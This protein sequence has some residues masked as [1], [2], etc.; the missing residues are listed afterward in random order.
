VLFFCISAPRGQLE[1]IMKPAVHPR[2]AVKFRDVKDGDVACRGE[3]MAY[4]GGG[5]NLTGEPNFRSRRLE[6]RARFAS[7]MVRRCW[8]RRKGPWKRWA[9]PKAP[10]SRSTKLVN[11]RH[12]F[13]CVSHPQP[14]QHCVDDNQRRCL[15][16]G[17]N[18]RKDLEAA[19]DDCASTTTNHPAARAA[20]GGTRHGPRVEVAATAR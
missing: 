8:R 13:V 15:C 11:Q 19:L 4:K 1:L 3:W 20:A 6:W 2:C 5:V 7:T 12:S 17:A 10:T 18:A 14:Q 9:M 16:H